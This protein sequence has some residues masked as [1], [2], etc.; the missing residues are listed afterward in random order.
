MHRFMEVVYLGMEEALH[1]FWVEPSAALGGIAAPPLI[2]R[3]KGT[4]LSVPDIA[5]IR[6]SGAV[7]ADSVLTL[8]EV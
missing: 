4:R 5:W 6:S 7:F 3:F 1:V 8:I 2:S